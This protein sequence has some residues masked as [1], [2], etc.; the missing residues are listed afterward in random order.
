MGEAEE[1]RLQLLKDTGDGRRRKR[2][3]EA[4]VRELELE[5]DQLRTGLGRARQ[6]TRSLQR[7]LPQTPS[8]P[9]GEA[10][11]SGTTDADHLE[12][13]ARAQG[14]RR[15]LELEQEGLRAEEEQLESELFYS[16]GGE[17]PQDPSQRRRLSRQLRRLQGDLDV[18]QAQCAGR[19]A[20]IH[21]GRQLRAEAMATFQEQAGALRV[22]QAK[23]VEMA[24]VRDPSHGSEDPR[25]ERPLPTPRGS[26]MEEVVL[27]SPK[28]WTPGRGGGS[29]L[30]G[31]RALCGRLPVLL[32]VLLLL[33][34]LL[35]LPALPP[36]LL[37]LMGP[38]P[39]L[40]RALARRLPPAALR[41]LR[42]ALSPALELRA[43]R[44]LPT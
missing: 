24:N 18:L 12:Q 14:F 35:L 21:Q 44:L 40:P 23:V 17:D 33:P 34:L 31:L 7:R 20:R 13:F 30:T 37:V 16:A 15:S 11:D 19:E 32:P 10:G 27:V 22:L 2:Q 3:L 26:L 4:L 39:G 43:H 42:Y 6:R 36:L 5:R 8:R 28:C 25:A 38:G 41:Q 29:P 9:R 1:R